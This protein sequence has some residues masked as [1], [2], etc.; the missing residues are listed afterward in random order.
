MPKKIT[1][2][3]FE[4]KPKLDWTH[5]ADQRGFVVVKDWCNV[6]PA[7]CWFETVKEA[8]HGINVLLKVKGNANRFWEIMQPFEFKRV[9][10]KASFENGTVTQ[11]RFKA[12]IQN[13]RVVKLFTKRHA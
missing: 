4:I 3:G 13:F 11:G 2:K 8:R 1:Y 6:M 10:Q 7:A 5:A 9:G 12:I